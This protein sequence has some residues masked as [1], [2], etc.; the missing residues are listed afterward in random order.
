MT[1]PIPTS[2]KEMT[3]RLT[4]CKQEAVYFSNNKASGFYRVES[5][6][7]GLYQVAETGKES[8][9]RLYGKGSYFGYR[10]LFTHQRYPATARAME[11]SVVSR[12]NVHTFEDL[13]QLAPSLTKALTTEVC[14]ELGEAE[15]R[16]VQFSAFNAKNRI[17]DAIQHFFTYYPHYPWTYREI[18][19][20]SAT[21]VTTVIRFCKT[22]KQSGVLSIH[23]RN[24]HPV[25]L[26]KL[27]SAN[28][29]SKE[30]VE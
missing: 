20:Y 6:F 23:H 22:L 9:L 10:S 14:Q 5:G 15:R 19:E 30:K 28:Q 25:D 27:P 12:V 26:S 1:I 29:L 3:S 2:V 21:D 17:I 13:Q 18:S 11:N 8:L 16:L 4:V 24:P 7:I